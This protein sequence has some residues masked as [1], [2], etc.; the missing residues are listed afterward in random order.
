MKLNK[1][2]QEIMTNKID[3]KILRVLLA[4]SYSL[5]ELVNEIGIAYKNLLPHIRKLE[6]EGW[7]KTKKDMNSRGQPVIVS[8]TRYDSKGKNLVDPKWRDLFRGKIGKKAK[9]EILEVVKELN[10][11]ATI[12]SITY[13]TDINIHGVWKNLLKGLLN[14]GYVQANFEITKEGEKFLNK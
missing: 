4:G 10:K 14:K 5:T 1:Q 9:K 8:S 12:E 13:L 3:L 11:K 6:K 2:T 7:L